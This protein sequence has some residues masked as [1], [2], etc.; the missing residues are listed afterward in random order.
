[1]VSGLSSITSVLGVVVGIAEIMIAWGLFQYT[2]QSL[3]IARL[4]ASVLLVIMGAGSAFLTLGFLSRHVNAYVDGR[5]G[6]GFLLFFPDFSSLLDIILILLIVN[7]GILIFT[8]LAILKAL[9]TDIP[10]GKPQV[11]SPDEKTK[12]SS[13][14]KSRKILYVPFILILLWLAY[15]VPTFF[16]F[17]FRSLLEPHRDEYGTPVS[18]DSAKII[19]T[20][21]TSPDRTYTIKESTNEITSIDY[22]ATEIH[23]GIYGKNDIYL[24]ELGFTIRKEIDGD[25]KIHGCDCQ[26]SFKGWINNHTFVIKTIKEDGTEYEDI[27]DIKKRLAE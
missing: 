10:D 13:V 19:S 27:I 17:D 8:V 23:F 9:K 12:V 20:S 11:S 22:P 3:S 25:G 18:A 24:D 14:R 16:D 7:T 15:A 21:L 5:T 6:G 4:Y 1:L 2:K 26:V